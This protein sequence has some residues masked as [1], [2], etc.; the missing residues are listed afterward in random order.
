MDVRIITATHQDLKALVDQGRF[1]ADLYYRLNTLT[2]KVP[3]LRDRKQDIPAL[4]DKFLNELGTQFGHL[5]LGITP[6]FM[7]KLMKHS[8]PGN[9]RELRHVLSRALLLEEGPILEGNEF[10]P[11]LVLHS[12]IP[13]SGSDLQTETR[14]VGAGS[15]LITN[16]IKAS[17]GNKSKA[18]KLLG[19]SRKT[20]YARLKKRTKESIHGSSTG[21]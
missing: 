5:V 9:V 4:V 16:A 11:D 10:I 7:A 1:R 21:Q 2:L 14:G 17:S 6:D 20:L 18:A 3:A 8:W 13:T 19:I 12:H 15:N